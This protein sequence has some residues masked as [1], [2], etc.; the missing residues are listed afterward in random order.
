VFQ[1]VAFLSLVVALAH[2]RDINHKSVTII[3]SMDIA[4]HA[5][6]LNILDKGRAWKRCATLFRNLGGIAGE[7]LE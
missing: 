4:Y 2:P 5:K 6:T 7:Y 1:A 3:C